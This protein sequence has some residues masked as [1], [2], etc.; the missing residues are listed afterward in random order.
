MAL[1]LIAELKNVEGVSGIHILA[2]GWEDIVPEIVEKAGF[3]P[4]PKY[5]DEV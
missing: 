3:L 4:R 5:K 1:E 2:V